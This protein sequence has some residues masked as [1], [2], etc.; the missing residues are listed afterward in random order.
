MNVS[1]KQKTASTL[2][3]DAK[4]ANGLTFTDSTLR[5]LVSFRQLFLWPWAACRFY[6]RKCSF[7]ALTFQKCR[8][9]KGRGIVFHPQRTK[10]KPFSTLYA[11]IIFYDTMG[12]NLRW[13]FS[14]LACKVD[15]KSLFSL[16]VCYFLLKKVATM[17]SNKTKTTQYT[18]VIIQKC[19]WL[20]GFTA[21]GK[22]V[23]WCECCCFCAVE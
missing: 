15:E 12:G 1:P 22:V 2:T 21:S 10:Y 5:F 20:F 3:E 11:L 4:C 19:F 7:W 17:A 18:S 6:V 13:W 14:F 23:V 16:H 9:A 8:P